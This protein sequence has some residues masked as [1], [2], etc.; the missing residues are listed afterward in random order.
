MR[1]WHASPDAGQRNLI[2]HQSGSNSSKRKL[3]LLIYKSGIYWWE[4]RQQ[5]ITLTQIQ[6][7]CPSRI[8]FQGTHFGEVVALAPVL[9]KP[10]TEPK[11]KPKPDLLRGQELFNI[12]T[13]NVRTLNTINPLLEVIASAADKNIDIVYIQEHKYYQSKVEL[14]YLESGNG[15]TFVSPSAWENSINAAIGG[16]GK[17]NKSSAQKSLNS[18]QNTQL[19]MMSAIFKN[20]SYTTI[21]SCYSLNNTSDEMDIT[22]FCNKVSSLVHHI[23]KHNVLIISRV[24]NAHIG[25]DENNRFC[26]YNLPN[27]NGKHLTEFYFKNRLVCLN[28][29]I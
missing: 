18:I 4:K 6:T 24:I 19:R 7:K 3:L 8:S 21:I 27:R 23:P 2:G 13:F 5:K 26:V 17:L 9:Q 15:W 16:V 22:T 1:Q 29:K 20:N 11:P 28:I 10:T 14:K 12:T 25:K